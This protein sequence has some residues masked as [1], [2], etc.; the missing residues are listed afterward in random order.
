MKRNLKYILSLVVIAISAITACDNTDDG[1]GGLLPTE[2][3]TSDDKETK[4]QTLLRIELPAPGNGIF[5]SHKC[6][7]DG[8]MLMN[9]CVEYDATLHHSRWVAYRFDNRY[10]NKSGVKRKDYSI[11]PQ[12]PKDPDC[13]SSLPDDLSFRGYQ[14]GHI[15]A[16][17]DRRCSREA[18]DQTF[19]MTNMSP[20]DGDFNSNYWPNY[21]SYVRDMAYKKNFADT[22]YVVKGGTIRFGEC[23]NITSGSYKLAV[24]N[25]YFIAL[26]RVNSGRYD[27]I[28]F[29]VDHKYESTLDIAKD[30]REHAM[31]IDALEALT[32]IDFFHNLPDDIE[33]SVESKVDNNLWGL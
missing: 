16:S 30:R 2:T 27:A 20:M 7:V 13:S 29:L 25:Q 4:D 9:Y 22:L 5:V 14:H 33:D 21:E 12:Y 8:N 23:Q 26:L 6:E 24:P 17:E 18:N 11:K 19:Y 32:G 28:G 1:L 3:Q 15:V 10:R 31:S